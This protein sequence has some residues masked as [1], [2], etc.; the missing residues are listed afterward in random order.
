MHAHA[1]NSNTHVGLVVCG[2]VVQATALRK[3]LFGSSYSRWRRQGSERAYVGCRVMGVS[4]PEI[5][6]A[7]YFTVAAQWS[8]KF[9]ERS[10]GGGAPGVHVRQ[11]LG[12]EVRYWLEGHVA[13]DV[14]AHRPCNGGAHCQATH[15]RCLL[16]PLRR[17]LRIHQCLLEV[18][19]IVQPAD[20]N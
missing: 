11:L 19:S 1:H 2:R 5:R 8:E 4:Y 7:V 6:E 15:D 18:L 13:E 10:Y 17:H 20:S 14:L 3:P 12:H 9:K 16:Q